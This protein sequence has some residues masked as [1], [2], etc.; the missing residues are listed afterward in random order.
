MEELSDT[1]RV[2]DAVAREAFLCETRKL[3]V[4][5]G[6]N[7]RSE[8]GKIHRNLHRQEEES[9]IIRKRGKRHQSHRI[10]PTANYQSTVTDVQ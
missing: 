8:R 2:S 5:V 6:I 3:V 7:W 10:A 9:K 4:P 1:R